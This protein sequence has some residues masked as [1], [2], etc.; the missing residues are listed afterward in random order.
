MFNYDYVYSKTD[1][2]NFFAYFKI[3]KSSS[4]NIMKQIII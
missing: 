2:H 1:F 4:P 3:L